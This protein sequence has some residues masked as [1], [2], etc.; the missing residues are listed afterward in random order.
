MV[1]NQTQKYADFH[2]NLT[3]NILIFLIENQDPFT[4]VIHDPS[5]KYKDQF[6]EESYVN[7]T[8]HLHLIEWS[9]EEASVDKEYPIMYTTLAFGNDNP[10]EV[11]VAIDAI[12]ISLIYLDRA[13]SLP[14]LSRPF[15]YE[16]AKSSSQQSE[17]LPSKPLDLHHI[18]QRA[19]DYAL[20][21]NDEILH[22]MSK[23]TLLKKDKS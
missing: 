8:I 1:Q 13:P 18:H 17:P 12:D 7:N 21:H 4:L 14:L 5:R 3:M 19:E 9:L 22:S 15:S 10:Y 11:P 16:P 2:I 23:L 20:L 6:P